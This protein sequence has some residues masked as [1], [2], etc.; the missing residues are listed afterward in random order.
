[1]CIPYNTYFSLGIYFCL[2]LRWA[3]NRENITSGIITCEIIF[4]HLSF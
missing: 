1:M 4:S 3:V 2:F